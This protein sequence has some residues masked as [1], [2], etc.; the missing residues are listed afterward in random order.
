MKHTYVA[1]GALGIVACGG[2][3]TPDPSEG[4]VA[5]AQSESA[6]ANDDPD[7]DPAAGN[8][9]LGAR[10]YI[11]AD[12][13][14]KVEDTASRHPDQAERIRKVE[15]YPTAVW[16]DSI[17]SV[18]RV[19]AALSAAQEQAKGDQ[20]MLTAF[21]VYDLPNRDCSA[22]ASSG[23]LLVSQGGQE[24]YKKE[25]ID[26]IA[27]Q[28]SQ[29]PDQRIVVILE[30]DSLPNL[31][32]NLEVARCAEAEGA[33]RESIA[34]AISKL[35]GPNVSIY[36][37]AAHAGW[38]GWNGN[39][40]KLA[41]LF[42]E[43]LQRAGGNQKIRGFVTNVANF[44][45]LSAAEGERLG[46][47]NPCPDELSYV[48]QLS[49]AL[50]RVGV[51]NKQFIIDTS[52]NGRPVRESWGNWCNIE[53][54]GLGARP[55]AAPTAGVDAYFWIKPPGESDG[56]SDPSQPRFDK[57]CQS[58][59]SSSGAPQAGKW[60]ESYFLALVENASPAL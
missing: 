20:P 3:M 42:G 51:T 48:A 55:Q 16:L 53:G 17:K 24:R 52:R 59:D 29:F 22:N 37:D 44:N 5:A 35:A 58:S 34:Y 13:V 41:Q 54:A 11:N 45:T 12:Y 4:T 38:T 47:G 7:F 9:F 39:R 49:D 25:F 27:Q 19:A 15:A 40:E 31:V 36:L 50:R 2:A 60:F 28:F 30:P 32:T 14:R 57:A 6:P 8:P 23:E 1:I 33:Y 43:V 18:K 26:P 10:F 21:V 46:P 56:I